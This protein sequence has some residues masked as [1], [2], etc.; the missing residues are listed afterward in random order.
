MGTGRDHA[1]VLRFALPVAAALLLAACGR[2]EEAPAPFVAPVAGARQRAAEPEPRPGPKVFPMA[3]APLLDDPGR[4]EWQRPAEVIAALAIR[5]GQRIADVGC[6]TGYFTLRLLRAAGP[7]GRVLAVDVQQGMLDL[8]AKRLAPGEKPLVVLRRN[9]P[10][11]PLDAADAVDLV[12]CANTLYEVDDAAAARFVGSMAEGLVPGGRLAIIEWL[13]QRT[14]FGPPV[15]ARISPRRVR[16]LAEGA[17]LILSEDL[18]LLPMH[19]FL[20]FTRPK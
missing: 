13:P 6:G 4:D 18:H 12:F 20:V 16:E 19:S 1:L 15:E 5:P 10:D 14:R 9:A 7:T 3:G 17:G 11:R 2:T 8:L